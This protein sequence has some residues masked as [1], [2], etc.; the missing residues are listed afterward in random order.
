MEGLLA[1][2]RMVLESVSKGNESIEK[3]SETTS[4]TEMF[5]RTILSNLRDHGII[6]FKKG[7]FFLNSELENFKRINQPNNL[8]YEIK[9]LFGSLVDNH[10]NSSKEKP[11]LK[12]Q[13][14]WLTEHEYKILKSMM[15]NMESY[16][17]SIRKDRLLNPEQEV[18]AE[19]RVI[20][21]GADTYSNLI[22][23]TLKVA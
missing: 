10:Y 13:K 7:K 19:E 17:K 21:W 16:I 18:I 9:D 12:M 11:T 15:I 23:Q 1:V 22:S 20:F 2:E 5:V 14:I 3:I 8:K 4:L 6:K